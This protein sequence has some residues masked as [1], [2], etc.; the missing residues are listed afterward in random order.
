M[1][2]FVFEESTPNTHLMNDWALLM[3]LS[4]PFW[5]SNRG[6]SACLQEWL[7]SI[8]VRSHGLSAADCSRCTSGGHRPHRGG[9]WRCCRN[10]RVAWLGRASPCRSLPCTGWWSQPLLLDLVHFPPDLWQ[11]TVSDLPIQQG[12]TQRDL[13]TLEVS[14]VAV[15]RRIARLRLGPHCGGRGCL[16]CTDPKRWIRFLVVYRLGTW[17]L[18]PFLL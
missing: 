8:L 17:A 12:E 10:I 15:V 7:C 5:H 11:S 1:G 18:A 13:T 6:S 3:H 2:R 4:S 16:S 9:D 14:H